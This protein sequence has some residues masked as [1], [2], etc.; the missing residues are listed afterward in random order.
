MQADAGPQP[1]D[2]GPRQAA[3]DAALAGVSR[4]YRALDAA[5]LTRV[6]PGA[7][8]AALSQRFS[9]LKYQSLSFDRCNLRPV[10]AQVV[11]SCEVSV[12]AAA[13]AGD[14][15]LQ[16]RQESWAIVLNR[17]GDRY[18]IGSVAVTTR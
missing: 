7:D 1:A 3:V 14:P 16:R 9:T 2:A 6:W 12:A 5:S 8:V 10:G 11:A 18:V 13:N 4:S 17:S 15:S